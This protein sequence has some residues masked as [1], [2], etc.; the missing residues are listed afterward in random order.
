MQSQAITGNHRQAQAGTG[1]HLLG[2]KE[3]A[4]Q[5]PEHSPEGT[6]PQHL[7]HRLARAP[8]V[9]SW[10]KRSHV[11]ETRSRHRRRR[12]CCRR[13]RRRCCALRKPRN[14]RSHPDRPRPQ[15]RWPASA[16][17]AA[18]PPSWAHPRAAGSTRE[19][20]PMS[21]GVTKLSEQRAGDWAG[22]G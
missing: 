17:V 8:R 1:K 13:W 19:H 12:P 9:S 16:A 7:E 21:V 22:R 4:G 5:E 6:H 18:R 2:H 15:F 20:A 10:A 3:Q 14:W 11:A